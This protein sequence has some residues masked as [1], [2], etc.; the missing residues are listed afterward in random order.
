MFSP[1][2][3]YLLVCIQLQPSNRRPVS[4]NWETSF[5][6]SRF[7]ENMQSGVLA[8]VDGDFDELQSVTKTRTEGPYELKSVIEY[9]RTI[10]GPGDTV[11]FEG[12]AAVQRV[13]SQ[14][15]VKITE[16]QVVETEEN[17]KV[18]YSTEFVI[19]P[20]GFAFVGDSSGVFAFDLLEKETGVKI[21]R[22]ELDLVSINDDYSDA[23]T[24]QA[25]FYGND[26]E[27]EK[28]VVYGESVMGDTD[29]GDV[30]SHSRL[31]Q[32]GLEFDMGDF[33]V[34]MTSAE[35]GYIEIYTPDNFETEEFLEFTADY[36]LHHSERQRPGE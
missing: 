25:G 36:L 1:Y 33:Y 6:L 22:A 2:F 9:T 27:A 20:D 11:A 12:R 14:D 35:S 19:V 3:S 23:E 30:L 28:G 17:E 32:L 5:N 21:N 16:N 34:K 26:G 29:L 8:L 4:G 7:F 18:T 10:E 13:E 15:Q 31:N 24:W